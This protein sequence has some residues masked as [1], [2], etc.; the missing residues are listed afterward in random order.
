MS[1]AYEVLM[2]TVNAGLWMLLFCTVAV[3][4]LPPWPPTIQMPC[5]STPEMLLF[6]TL[7]VEAPLTPNDATLIPAQPPPQVALV[8][9]L[10]VTVP[11]NVAFVPLP[12]PTVIAFEP[13]LCVVTDVS[14][15]TVK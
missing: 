10:L 1:I 7:T 3:R 11:L 5:A 13:R 14:P 15:A 12:F 2:P 6:V 4:E 8:M 9:T